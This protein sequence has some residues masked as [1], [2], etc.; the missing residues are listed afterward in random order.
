MRDEIITGRHLARMA[1]LPSYGAW[2]K[3]MCEPRQVMFPA[4]NGLVDYKHPV[5]ARIDSGRWIGDCECGG[6]EYVDP[7]E[8]IFFC[9]S[10]GNVRF[11]S[12]ARSVIF[13]RDRQEIERLILARPVRMTGSNPIERA[14]RAVPVIGRLGRFYNPGETVEM[15]RQQNEGLA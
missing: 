13:P 9:L 4:W 11:K 5:Y 15:L 8:P 1:R 3:M 12:C 6:A 14:F 2:I 10:C 7:D